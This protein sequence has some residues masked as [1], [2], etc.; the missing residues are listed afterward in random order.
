MGTLLGK[1]RDS[2]SLPMKRNH[3]VTI[4]LI[5]GISLLLTLSSSYASYDDLLEADFLSTG[6]KYE[7]RDAD[8]FLLEKQNPANMTEKSLPAFLLFT[9]N[10]LVLCS[11]FSPPPGV[12]DP[13]LSALRC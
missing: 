5:F 3:P 2:L 6:A 1:K 7:T 11:V 10:S 12:T 13:T 9:G 8:D 4:L